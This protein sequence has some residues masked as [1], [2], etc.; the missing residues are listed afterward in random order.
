MLNIR[1]AGIRVEEE[2]TIDIKKDRFFLDLTA[3]KA[4]KVVISGVTTDSLILSDARIDH[5]SIHATTI[6]VGIKAKGL[7]A[8]NVFISR[9]T[10]GWL[11]LRNAHIHND[12]TLQLCTVKNGIE[13][14]GSSI[15]A[16]G[17]LH[18]R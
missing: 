2:L 18:D 3:L 10:T 4:N 13:L 1:L 5:L 15:S 9:V 17:L 12:L 14:Q 11:D 6:A 16:I 8:N 7:S